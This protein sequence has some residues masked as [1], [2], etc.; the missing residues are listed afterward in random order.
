MVEKSTLI[1]SWLWSC[2]PW[3]LGAPSIS[4]YSAGWS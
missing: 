2:T 3:F 1:R 4:P